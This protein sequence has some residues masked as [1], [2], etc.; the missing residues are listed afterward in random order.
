MVMTMKSATKQALFSKEFCIGLVGVVVAIFISSI[1]DI[2]EV[3]RAEG[4][5]FNGFHR[6]FINKAI[7][8]DEMVLVLPVIAALPFTAT[9]VNDIKSGFIKQYL[10][11]TSRTAYI[12]GKCVAC[13]IS[14]GLVI[15]LGVI[16]SY[17]IASLVFMPMEEPVSKDAETYM[18]YIKLLKKTGLM[19]L[20]GSVWSMCGLTIATLTNSKY[21]AYASPFIIY[22]I[23]I[24][25]YERYF[26]NLYV[27]YPK[28]WTN[29]SAKWILGEFGAVILH[30]GLILVIS[31]VFFGIA[32]RRISQ[33]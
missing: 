3:T 29:P 33:L 13:I 8:S 17:I 25:L 4:L 9:F 32:K 26:K 14:G 11:R 20:S 31:I 27:L 18:F 1:T 24:I 19:F 15:S 6:T 12:V 22:Y 7:A 21:M 10:H 30:L 28:E 5:I 16:V 2:I 23:L